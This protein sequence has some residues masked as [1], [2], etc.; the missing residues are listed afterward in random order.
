M[1][2]RGDGAARDPAKGFKALILERGHRPARTHDV[3]ELLNLATT[4]GWAVSLSMDDAVFLNSLYRGR[5]PTEEGLLPH[6]EP[7]KEDARRALQAAGGFLND[8]RSA[9]KDS[10]G[11]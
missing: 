5:Y 9:L 4:D 2:L 3:V 8:L 6:G 11:R 1:G 7:A 10:S